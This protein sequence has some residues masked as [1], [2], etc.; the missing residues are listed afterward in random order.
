MK[1]W[2]FIDRTYDIEND[3]EDCVLEL[4]ELQYVS[5]SEADF[6]LFKSV[7]KG[8]VKT[9]LSTNAASS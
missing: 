3:T 6:V 4:M 1:A 9:M 5:K 2:K 7:D 8:A